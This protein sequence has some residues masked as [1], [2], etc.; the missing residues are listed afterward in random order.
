[1]LLGQAITPAILSA[2]SGPLDG[3]VY[4]DLRANSTFLST[5][6]GSANQ[7]AEAAISKVSIRT[8]TTPNGAFAKFVSPVSEPV[9]GLQYLMMYVGL[10]LGDYYRYHPDLFLRQFAYLWDR[11]FWDWYFID[12][13]WHHVIGAL[14]AVF[15]GYWL[16]KPSDGLIPWEKSVW[17]TTIDLGLTTGAEV[18]HRGQPTHGR[19]LSELN[20]RLVNTFGVLPRS[21]P[22]PPPPPPPPCQPP[23]IFGC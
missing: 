3:P 10:T 20:F 22:P 1:M 12:P 14:G 18:V 7:G 17:G 6:N 16:H 15:G 21:V 4:T 13:G 23:F 2:F 9:I 19:V 8:Q 11:V 5:I